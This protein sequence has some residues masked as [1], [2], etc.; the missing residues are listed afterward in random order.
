MT[1]AG[2]YCFFLRAVA[3]WKAVDTR[4]TTWGAG[5]ICEAVELVFFFVTV[6]LHKRACCFCCDFIERVG[7]TFCG[8]D[9]RCFIVTCRLVVVSVHR[10]SCSCPPQI[11]QIQHSAGRW[12]HLCQ[13]LLLFLL[14][15]CTFRNYFKSLKSTTSSPHT[16]IASSMTAFKSRPALSLIRRVLSVR[17]ELDC[18]A[19]L[20]FCSASR[21]GDARTSAARKP[22]TQGTPACPLSNHTMHTT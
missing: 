19:E 3:V 15:S 9:T 4:C 12:L 2:T 18:P 16:T 14:L 1:D 6:A 17:S 8:L 20:L 22:Y 7:F 11:L 21:P 10:S 13:F 5:T